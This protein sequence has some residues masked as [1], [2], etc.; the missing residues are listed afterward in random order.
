MQGA[1]YTVMS[2]SFYLNF[3]HIQPGSVHNTRTY[4]YLLCCMKLY[5]T[6]GT[7][8]PIYAILAR[9]TDIGTVHG[10]YGT[11]QNS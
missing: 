1:S 4:P 9:V 11:G 6:K 7:A 2:V 8:M 10:K 3:L 5:N